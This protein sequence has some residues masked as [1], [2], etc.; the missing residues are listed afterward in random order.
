MAAR[1]FAPVRQPATARIVLGTV[2]TALALAGAVVPLVAVGLPRAI[3]YR[4]SADA[5][6]V[7]L[8]RT[9]WT[10]EKVFFRDRIA[11]AEAVE[12]PRGRR[13]VGTSLPGYC[14]GTFTYPGI[15]AVWQATDCSR[16]AVLLTLEV[17]PHKV[18]LSPADRE[19]FLAAL[20]AG[21]AETFCPTEGRGSGTWS[22]WTLIVLLP[23]L[24]VLVLP[25]IFFLAPGKLRYAVGSGMLEVRTMFVRRRFPL[26]GATVQRYRPG[27]A[28]K[29][30]GSGF[31]GY[32][33]G[34]FHLD[35]TST[36]VFATTVKDGVLVAGDRRVFVTPADA[37]A[38]LATLAEHG[39][40]IV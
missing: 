7:T 33:T 17:P 22:W 25:V 19:G 30:I 4:T 12:L 21:A 14:V 3:S 11:T 36:K 26:A 16:A 37:E 31:P 23:L 8:D 39:A 2:L 10:T 15:G 38:F 40:T 34:T 20:K 32:Y 5:V 24:V 28:F 1:E 35:G 27:S 29:L 9:L 13:T 18:V 6:M